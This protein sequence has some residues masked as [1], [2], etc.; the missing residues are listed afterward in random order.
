MSVFNRTKRGFKVQLLWASIW[1]SALKVFKGGALKVIDPNGDSRL[2]G[3]ESSDVAILEIKEPAFYKKTVL[4]GSVAFGEAYEAGLWSSPDLSKLLIALSKNCNQFGF[5]E[6][7]ASFLNQWLNI[8]LHAI[9]HNSK[10]NSLSNIQAHYDLSNE[11][12]KCFLDAS[13]TYSSALFQNKELDLE[14]AQINKINRILD[15][16]EVKAGDSVLEIGSGWGSLAIEAAKRGCTVRTL[17]LSKEQYNLTQQKIHQLGL[18]DRVSVCLQDYRDELG[19]YDAVVSCEMIEAVGKEYLPNYFSMIHKVLKPNSKAVIQA[20]TIC[21]R[22]YEAY[23][24]SCDWIQ[25]HIFPGGH[26]PSLEVIRKILVNIDAFEVEAID[27]FGF[28]YAK[29][30]SIWQTNFNRAQSDVLK[31]GFDAAFLRKWNFYF[32][33]CIAGFTNRMIDVNHIVLKKQS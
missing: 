5:L 13:M 18:E 24:K 31:L 32:S 7:G 19:V 4:G 25:K 28:D 16:A 11:F 27:S 3:E 8:A 21:D 14:A 1:N 15:L 26:L 30:L 9:R 2:Y 10:K 29:T 33:Y 23:S 12:Y 17:T 22:D 6:K 20:I